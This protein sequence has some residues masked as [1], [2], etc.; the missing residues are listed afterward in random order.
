MGGKKRYYKVS[1]AKPEVKRPLGEKKTVVNRR[2]ILKCVFKKIGER[3][4]LDISGSKRRALVNA[5]MT[6]RTP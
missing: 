4:G 2:I 5:V 1:A 6:F 3:R